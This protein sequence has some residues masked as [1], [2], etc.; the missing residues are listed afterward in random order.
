MRFTAT[1]LLVIT[2]AITCSAQLIGPQSQNTN[3]GRLY[4]YWGWNFGGFSNSDIHFKGEG[5]DF[6]LSDVT[7]MD[8]Q[9]KYNT[10]LYI[11]PVTMTIPQ[12]NFRIG[13]FFKE[14]YSFSLGMDHMKYVMDQNQIVKFTGKID[15]SAS[16]VFGG[17]NSSHVMLNKHFLMFEHT[18]GL[19]Y[20]NVDVRRHEELVNWKFITVN[21]M[22]GL[23]AGALLPKTNALLME[24]E[25]ND[26]FHLAGYGFNG[27]A[28]VNLTV[29]RHFYIQSELKGGY[30]NMPDIRTTPSKSDKASQSF[31]FSQLNVVFGATINLNGERSRPRK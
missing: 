22:G 30:I 7:A 16:L 20:I 1:A 28:G 24:N 2:I 8:R 5:Y 6:T 17:F 27:L 18:D 9:S 29:F 31:W 21:L 12:Y 25:R 4:I 19:N 10:D 13:Y 26:E 15:S 23:G 11:N 14:N 3:K